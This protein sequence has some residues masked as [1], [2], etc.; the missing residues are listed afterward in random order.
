MP[1]WL[2]PSKLPQMI[3][4][5][6]KARYNTARLPG[7]SINIEKLLMECC[8]NLFYVFKKSFLLFFEMMIQLH[9]FTHPFP[10]SKYSYS[11]PYFLSNSEPQVSLIVVIYIPKYRNTT[12]SVCIILLVYM[13][14]G[15]II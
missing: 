8:V 14:S 3:R 11:S 2:S 10:P 6:Q 12:F 1:C 5:C 15:M 7:D 13:F 9:H 4:K